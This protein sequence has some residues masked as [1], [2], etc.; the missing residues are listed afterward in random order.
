MI[1]FSNA[2]ARRFHH[3]LAEDAAEADDAQR[4]AAHAPCRRM[5]TRPQ[6][7]SLVVALACGIERAMAS[8]SPSV[9]S[10]TETALPPGVFM[11]RT[12]AAV[13]A[14]TSIFSAPVPAL[15]ITLRRGAAASRSLSTAIELRTISASA[16]ARWRRNSSG[17]EVMT[18]HPG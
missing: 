7:P 15:P 6:S 4:L 10:A 11:M 1:S 16:S 17:V 2:R 3:F 13:A 12:P 9:C 8:I 5:R 14:S 18:F